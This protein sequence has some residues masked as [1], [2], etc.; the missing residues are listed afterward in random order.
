[1]RGLKMD[2]VNFWRNN[3][4][5]LEKKMSALLAELKKDYC[6]GGVKAEFEAEGTRLDEAMRLKNVTSS[7]GLGLNIK[8]G[9][10]EAIKDM[11]DSISLGAERIIAPMV[12]TPYALQK[13]IRAAQMV[14]GE[15]IDNVELLVNIETITA[16]NNFAEML[17]IPEIKCLHGIVIGRVDFTG[18]LGLTR[19]AVNS[20]DML[21]YCLDMA[22]KAKAKGLEVVV[23]G[24]VSVDSLKFFQ[25]FPEGHIDRYETR[26][27]IYDC[28][29]A[30]KNPEVAFV[31]AVEFELMW[32]KNKR[33]YYGGIAREDETR[34]E[35]MEA[36]YRASIEKLS[37][38]TV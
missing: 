20:D 36:R 4:N 15:N 13:F 27:V 23:G 11:L 9:G 22:A 2:A 17:E 1:M 7:A 26:K 21:K 8:I 16:F 30:L 6:V 29:A 35:M 14:Y 33:D 25:A 5:S 19:E 34:I 28:P 12:E 37:T 31:K 10:C 3:M 24:G 18:S 38:E 32:L